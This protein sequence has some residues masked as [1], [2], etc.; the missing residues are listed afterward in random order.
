MICYDNGLRLHLVSLV[1]FQNI[2]PLISTF[3]KTSVSDNFYSSHSINSQYPHLATTTSLHLSFPLS[4]A[5]ISTA[6]P[7][8]KSKIVTAGLLDETTQLR[9][10]AEWYRRPLRLKHFLGAL[11]ITSTNTLCS[12]MVAR[13]S[14]VIVCKTSTNQ[15]IIEHFSLP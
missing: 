1:A 2:F 7:S 14:P 6:M 11:I 8:I 3:P 4:H 9:K 15:V 12:P 13:Y 10:I 5:I